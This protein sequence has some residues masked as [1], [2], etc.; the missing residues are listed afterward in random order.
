MTGSKFFDPK[1][2]LYQTK[3][4]HGS[5]VADLG[6]GTGFFALD[7]S[8]IVGENGKVFVVDVLEPALQNV[9]SWARVKHCGNIFTVRKDLECVPISQIPGGTADLVILSNVLHQIK[10]RKE[11]FFEAYRLLKTG[12]HLLALDWNKS[13][14]PIGPAVGERVSEDE[15]RQLAMK[16]NLRFESEIESDQYHF[17]LSFIK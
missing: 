12:G 4:K 13:K 2:I 11:L 1:N 3:I 8:A 6:A 10:K 16:A 17:A 5:V 7:A 15:I 9:A 14:G